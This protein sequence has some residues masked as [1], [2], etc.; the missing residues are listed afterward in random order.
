[1]IGRDDENDSD[2]ENKDPAVMKAV[3][4]TPPSKK[5]LYKR[6]R[7]RQTSP[8]VHS[9]QPYPVNMCEVCVIFFAKMV[10][11][12]MSRYQTLN[13]IIYLY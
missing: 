11:A 7:E 6:R 4:P 2:K 12:C 8:F 10:H 5:R 3:Q 9:V 1:M 13:S